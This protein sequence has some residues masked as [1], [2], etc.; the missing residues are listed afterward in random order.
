MGCVVEAQSWSPCLWE[1]YLVSLA[2]RLGFNLNWHVAAALGP[3]FLVRCRECDDCL[4]VYYARKE[5]C[6]PAPTL[7]PPLWQH[8]DLALW[9]CPWFGLSPVSHP[10]SSPA[11]RWQVS[12]WNFGSSSSHLSPGGLSIKEQGESGFC[13][14]GCEGGVG[15]G[16]QRDGQGSQ[17]VGWW[18]NEIMPF[19]ATWMDL[20][21]ITV[22]EVSQAEKDKYHM[23]SFICKI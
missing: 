8:R 10:R 13:G 14:T 1:P 4:C 7:L 5:W 9:E 16:S 15:L 20:A 17:N 21:I 3:S 2:P 11:I 18:K 19:A 12:W 22:R 23:I 6:S